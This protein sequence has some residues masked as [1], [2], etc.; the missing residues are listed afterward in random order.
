MKR[1]LLSFICFGLLLGCTKENIEKKDPDGSGK[2]EVDYVKGVNVIDQAAEDVIADVDEEGEVYKLKKG[3]FDKDPKPGDVIVVSGEMMRKV[4]SVK[5][6]GNTYVVDT[7]MVPLTEVVKN[8]TF[9]FDIE[10]EW[11]DATSMRINGVEMLNEGKRVGVEPIEFEYTLAHITYTLRITPQMV[12]GKI[13]HCEVQMVAFDSKNKSSYSATGTATLPRQ[14]TN[15]VIKDG[16]LQDFSSDN[17][18]LTA[19]FEIKLA[20][21]GGESGITKLTL[22]DIAIKI[23]LR[24]IPTPLGPVINPIPMDITVGMKLVTQA[25][26]PDPRSSATVSSS[27]SYSANG[28]FKLNGPKINATGALA[29]YAF[30][31]GEFDSAANIGM[32]ANLEFGIAFPRVSFNIAGQEVAF[33]HAGYTTG[34][35]L[36]WNGFSACKE[37]YSKV[38]VEGGYSLSILGQTL[39]ED[40]VNF[41]E[42]RHDVDNG[43]CN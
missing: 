23:P 8:G 15:I 32:P 36:Y 43:Y 25:R 14:K 33:V 3:A 11:S 42:E 6:S 21:A 38:V 4:K 28:G 1:I 29:D 39:L 40:T 2:V 19:S 13:N 20:S 27:A 9:A 30:K 7:E 24:V 31:G 26:F 41:I 16:K 12:N 18:G 10:P 37:G 34:S 5:S 17:D 35:N 22:P